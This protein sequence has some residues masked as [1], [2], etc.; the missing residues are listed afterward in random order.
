M[1]LLLSEY[2]NDL[3]KDVCGDTSGHFKRLLVIL[4]QVNSPVLFFTPPFSPLLFS[5]LQNILSSLQANKQRDIHEESIENDAQV[6]SASNSALRN[7]TCLCVLLFEGVSV[8][9]LRTGAK[10]YT[11]RPL[12]ICVFRR[13]CCAAAVMVRCRPLAE[14]SCKH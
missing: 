8:T 13:R 14:I 4:L 7:Q 1:C 3:E 9:C 11:V 5:L 12:C 6:R 10:A 2:D